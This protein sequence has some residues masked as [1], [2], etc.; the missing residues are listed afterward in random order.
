L[1]GEP[2]YIVSVW[3][4][5]PIKRLYYPCSKQVKW[6]TLRLGHL[7]RTD[8]IR[9]SHEDSNAGASGTLFNNLIEIGYIPCIAFQ[10]TGYGLG[11]DGFLVERGESIP[12]SA[13][14]SLDV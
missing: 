14:Y 6:A 1:V 4:D 11:C 5:I 8:S 2:Q 12:R 10:K 3:L 9:P 13:N 7:R